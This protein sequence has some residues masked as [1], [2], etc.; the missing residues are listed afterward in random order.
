MQFM[1]IC[2]GD[3][4]PAAGDGPAPRAVLDDLLRRLGDAGI[5]SPALAVA[6]APDEAAL[7]LR[8]W[9]G[10][11][12]V[13]AGPFPPG[14]RL[15]AGFAV[16]GAASREAAMGVLRT[17]A[18]ATRSGD[19]T[20]TIA[21][22]ATFELRETGCA[23]GC[24]GIAPDALD[25]GACWAILLRADAATERDAVPP[26]S[27]LDCLNAFNAA[28][29][30]AGTLLAGDGLKRSALGARLAVDPHARG[31]RAGIVDGPF[32]EA[33]EL[34]AGFWMVRADSRAAALAWARTLPYPT[35]PDVEVEIRRVAALAGP[36]G[37]VVDL[38]T[39]DFPDQH[40]D[41][42]DDLRADASLRAEGLDAALRAELAPPMAWD[43]P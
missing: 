22:G 6:F 32:A 24:A 28:E 9:S 37:A 43:R 26:Q 18:A 42:R 38:R 36:G 12:A 33:K 4:D 41:P 11:D 1:L 7:R 40:V 39:D 31:G 8:L 17:G 30:S 20:G 29:A 23:G 25:G 3:Q 5:G 16:F 27:R 19:V 2:C 21:G 15:P 14:E 10:G 34:I 35:G 13:A